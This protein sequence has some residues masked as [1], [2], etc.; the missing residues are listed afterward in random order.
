ML[1]VLCVYSGGYP[2]EYVTRLRDGVKANL[3]P[4]RFVCLTHDEIEGVECLKP[5]HDWP[6]WWA[7][8]EIFRPDLPFERV[9]YIDISSVIVGSLRDIAA[10]D[11]VCI[12]KDFYHGTPSQSVLLYNVGDF[13][14]TYA[15]FLEAPNRWMERGDLCTP[16]D[17]GDQIL[18][19]RAPVPDMRYWQ[20]V[21]PGHV[22]SY[23]VDCRDGVPAGAR[24]VKFHGKP[25]PHEVNWLE[26]HYI[27]TMNTDVRTMLAHMRLAAKRKLPRFQEVPPHGKAVCLVGGGPSLADTW[28]YIKGR[29]DVWALNNTPDYLAQHGIRPHVHV[30]LDARPDNVRFVEKANR[31]TIYLVSGQCHPKVFRKLEERKARVVLWFN[32]MP[33]VDRI[34]LPTDVM[35]GGGATVG[36]KAMYLAYCAGYR[37][38]H[39][40]GFDSSYRDDN[41][42]AYI[43]SLND[44]EQVMKIT[45]AGREFRCAPWMAKQAQEWMGQA[46][47][48]VGLGCEINVYGDGLI[49]HIAKH[50]RAA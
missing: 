5:L 11:G 41:H 28:H 43:Q 35:I 1:T 8:V 20:D 45:A 4:H 29:G 21:L 25:K 14:E 39:V 47:N 26:A 36:L 22:V 32:E 42:H 46:R 33:E 31:K 34:C 50:M 18:M 13:A 6:R 2:V 3:G 40:F 37:T 48:L 23:K 30:L 15:A 12:T 9:L 19:N 16:P 49:P 38:F 10:Q 24:L 44:G 7:K 27:Q 17:F